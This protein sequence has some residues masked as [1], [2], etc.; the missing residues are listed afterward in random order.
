MYSKPGGA[1]G[2]APIVKQ[3]LTETSYT[4]YLGILAV[5]P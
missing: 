5:N 1:F 2:W 3:W 4:W